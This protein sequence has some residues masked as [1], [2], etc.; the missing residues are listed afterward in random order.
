MDSDRLLREVERRLGHLTE[1]DR[2]EVVDAVREEIARDRRRLHP[3]L[4]VETERERRVAAE[5]I[6]DALEAINRQ[7]RLEGTIDEVLKQL[8]RIVSF[9]CC[10]LALA[11]SDDTFRI[12]AV[13]GF[14][15]PG[16]VVGTAMRDDL[17]QEIHSAHWP[18]AIAD[19][20]KD[21][22]FVSI[23]GGPQLRSWAG[24]PLLVEGESIGLLTLGRSHVEPFTEDELHRAKALAF[25][26]AAAIRNAR[27]LERVRRYAL[28]M[29]NVVAVDQAVFEGQE[30]R[31][32]SRTILEGALRLGSYRAGMI[33][34]RGQAGAY[35]YAALGDAFAGAEG[36][37][38]P[39]ELES[40]ATTRVEA[41]EV[42]RIGRMLG[43]SL[44]ALEIFLV[45]F[46]AA[47]TH[48][49][50]L[51]LLD[52]DGETPDDRLMESYASRTATAYLRAARDPA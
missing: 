4:T 30:P 16:A 49:G 36:K 9:D 11:E 10:V 39:E 3:S 25:S 29:E 28:L 40:E 45:P 35:V 43:V 1:A 52:P 7:A 24:M 17:M 41:A 31:E 8:A 6:R 15:E 48:V 42:P 5:T 21:A 18:I 14:T 19:V 34:L 47:V 22:R 27:I 37:P 44:P 46:A 23:A 33:V 20:E 13:R 26:A 51:V 12:L 50:T 2:A 32:V 38:A